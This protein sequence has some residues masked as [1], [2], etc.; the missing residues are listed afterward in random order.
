MHG[1]LAFLDF[2]CLTSMRSAAVSAPT[3]VEGRLSMV[4]R[5]RERCRSSNLQLVR[6]FQ[7]AG[8][9]GMFTLP[10]LR[11]VHSRR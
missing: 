9:L 5:R 10:S 1:L 7:E 4:D 6:L 2:L 3:V 8:S 11:T